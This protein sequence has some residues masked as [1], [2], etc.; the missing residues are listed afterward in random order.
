MS[1]TRSKCDFC[2][3]RILSS[4]IQETCILCDKSI[5]ASCSRKLTNGIIEWI[6][7]ECTCQSLSFNIVSD[8]GELKGLFNERDA[9]LN[10][11][12]IDADFFEGLNDEKNLKMNSTT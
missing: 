1:E 4:R 10:D 2:H 6:C 11:L 12:K 5:H 7:D 8:T 3:K 9:I